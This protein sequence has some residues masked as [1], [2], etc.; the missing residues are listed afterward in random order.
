MKYIIRSKNYFFD[1]IIVSHPLSEIYAD[2]SPNGSN[3]YFVFPGSLFFSCGS[4][5]FSYTVF[6]SIT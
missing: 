2:C 6:S 3:F 5:F 1:G 4:L